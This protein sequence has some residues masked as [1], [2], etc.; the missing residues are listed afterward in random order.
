[1]TN[2]RR[3][4]QVA[5]VSSVLLLLGYVSAIALQFSSL[6]WTVTER[7]LW[8]IEAAD[9]SNI[10]LILIT[11]GLSVLPI[12]LFVP[13]LLKARRRE[14]L[15]W[16]RELTVTDTLYYFALYQALTGVTYVLYWFVGG[17]FFQEDTSGGLIESFLSQILMLAGGLI[18]FAGRM[19]ELGF[20]RP[21]RV[22]SMI[23]AAVACY[24]FSTFLL[25]EWVTVPIADWLH[26]ELGSWREKQISG[27]V[28]QAR[29][30][31]LIMGLLEIVLIGVFV[32]I[33]EE[34][35]FRGVLQTAITNRFGVVAGIL[36]SSLLFSV[37]H[38]DPVFFPPLFI[39]GI[40]L[41]WLRHHYQ[42]IWA[43]ILFH[44]LNNSI[45]V[46]IYFFQK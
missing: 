7:G 3:W 8:R 32:P 19:D 27:G 21:V 40:M 31:G 33:A 44:S 35:M 25:D 13:A 11:I 39:M 24:L 18:L 42:S 16:E 17:A 26:F 28:T 6:R 14:L 4:E 37:F 36:G 43:S 45:T 23:G 41:G 20:V 1:M 5:V 22:L 29:D 46:L 2:N 38:V 9:E 10:W 34:M 15:L 12:A 30:L